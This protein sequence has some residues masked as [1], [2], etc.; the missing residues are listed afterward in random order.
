MGNQQQ[1]T[2]VE[3]EV[4]TFDIPTQQ[5]Q[6]KGRRNRAKQHATF[7][8]KTIDVGAAFDGDKIND[9]LDSGEES[10]E[11]RGGNIRKFI[12][13]IPERD[14][15]NPRFFKRQRF[16]DSREFKEALKNYAIVNGK[17][18]KP[19]KNERKRVRAK[20]KHPCRWFVFA[21]TVNCLGTNDLVVKS[22][23]D[24]HEN[25]GHA[26]KNRAITS[27]WLA[28]R[29]EERYR[30][31]LQLPVKELIQTVDEEYMSK[32][33]RAVAY[34]ARALATQT[35]K[36]S[37]EEQYKLLGRYSEELKKTHPGTTTE[38]VFTPFRKPGGNPTFMRFYCCL[39]PLKRGFFSGC[40]PLIGLDGCHIKGTHRGQL[41]TAMGVDPNNG[42]W[43]IA[44]AV[45]EKEAGEQWKWFLQL[46][47]DDLNIDNQHHYTFISDQQKVR[48]SI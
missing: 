16:A 25:C 44:W 42:W 39:G 8:S 9:Q 37:A 48:I 12:D 3:N 18:V 1:D 21:S 29:Y 24:K 17:P 19:S 28:N 34:K 36:G 10:S 14:M 32:I 6:K 40:R 31:N 46:L 43:P 47:A 7:G 26:W 23:Y 5:S 15:K 4:R 38:I 33:T 13:F 2:V 22:I 27:K 35:V 11:E 41:L 45:V 30:S 20:C